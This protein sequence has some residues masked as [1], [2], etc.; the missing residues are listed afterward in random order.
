M[1]KLDK[2]HKIEVDY[3]QRMTTEDWKGI[4]LRGEET[5]IF[6]NK[7]K[8]LSVRDLGYGVV[9]V[10]KQDYNLSV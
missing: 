3:R 7:Q 6:D 10:Y 8:G 2:R 9:E 1:T 5:I 4:L